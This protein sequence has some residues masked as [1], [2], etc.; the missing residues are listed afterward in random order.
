[1]IKSI[2]YFIQDQRLTSYSL[3]F[4]FNFLKIV[5]KKNA[6]TFIIKNFISSLEVLIPDYMQVQ[7]DRN[8]TNGNVAVCVISDAVN[9]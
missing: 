9:T 6:L 2:F 3:K 5:T 4:Q 8:I 1:M 7:E